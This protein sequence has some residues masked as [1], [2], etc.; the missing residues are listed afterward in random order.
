MQKEGQIRI[1]SGCAIAAVISKEG[2]K[3]M[4]AYESKCVNCQRYASLCPTKALKIS[5]TLSV[6]DVE[7]RRKKLG[8]MV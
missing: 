5:P 2:N 8:G 4:L 7:N 3:I 6:F 1:P